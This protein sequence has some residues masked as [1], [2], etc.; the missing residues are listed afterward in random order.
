MNFK[1]VQSKPQK[2]NDGQ[3]NIRSA[4]SSAG[5]VLFG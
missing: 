2:P 5:A 4:A 3:E 1:P